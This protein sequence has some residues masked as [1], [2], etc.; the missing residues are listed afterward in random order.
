M[1]ISLGNCIKVE[2]ISM[3]KITYLTLTFNTYTKYKGTRPEDKKVLYGTKLCVI[4]NQLFD[5][6][7]NYEGSQCSP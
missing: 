7:V 6:T 3:L 5:L 1:N 4:N 2:T